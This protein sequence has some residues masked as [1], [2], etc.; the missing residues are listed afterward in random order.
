MMDASGNLVCQL[1]ARSL[2][3]Q[4]VPRMKPLEGYA[5]LDREAYARHA[6]ELKTALDQRDAKAVRGIFESLSRLNRDT[7]RQAFIALKSQG[8]PDLPQAASS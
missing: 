3:L 8:G 2:L 6:R 5:E 1:I 4:L 7:A